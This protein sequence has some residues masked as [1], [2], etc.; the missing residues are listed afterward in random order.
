MHPDDNSLQRKGFAL[1]A[2]FGVFAVVSLLMPVSDGSVPSG[3]GIDKVVHFWIFF[4]VA[5]P[6]L[7]TAP[8]TWPWLV[9]MVILFGIALEFIQPYFGRGAEIGDAIANAL[10][11]ITAVPVGRWLHRFWLKPRQ[12]AKNKRA[13]RD[14]RLPH[15]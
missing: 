2:V 11:T 3:F 7:S 4:F 12:R 10:G 9:P 14:G 8:R 6:A 13:Q 5:L 15:R 1:S